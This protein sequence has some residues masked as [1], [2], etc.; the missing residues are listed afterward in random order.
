MELVAYLS[1]NYPLLVKV[2]ILMVI[3]TWFLQPHN[4]T[5][6]TLCGLARCF[7]SLT[8]RFVTKWEHLGSQFVS[9]TTDW[10]LPGVSLWE[11]EGDFL[12][13]TAGN[14][15]KKILIWSVIFFVL[16]GDLG[17]DQYR[18]ER[19]VNITLILFSRWVAW[20]EILPLPSPS[21]FLLYYPWNGFLFSH[22]WKVPV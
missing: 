16:A 22:L 1:H 3:D 21:H 9:S 8:G 6:N 5:K 12:K 20:L 15:K 14:E 17:L 11:V 7:H 2:A 19:F 4:T 10:V 18:S 13:S